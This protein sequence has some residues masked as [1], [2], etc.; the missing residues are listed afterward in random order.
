VLASIILLI[1]ARLHDADYSGWWWPL[2]CFT[3]LLGMIAV[4]AVS[5]T[6]GPNKYGEQPAGKLHDLVTFVR[7]ARG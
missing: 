1:V 4:A 2:V 5:G 3:S 7:S 6:K